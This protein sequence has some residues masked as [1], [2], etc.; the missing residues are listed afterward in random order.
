MVTGLVHHRTVDRRGYRA[1]AEKL[2]RRSGFLMAVH[3]GLCVTV[4]ALAS[5]A[6]WARVPLTPT[7]RQQGGIWHTLTG[8]AD[9]HLE[10]DYNSILPMYVVLLLWAVI[11]VA[12][13]H[14]GRR[15][16][17][18]AISL[19]VYVFGQTT[20]GLALTAGGFQIAA[21]QL[22]FTAGL[23]VGWEW[24]HGLARL[25]RH[26]RVGTLSAAVACSGVIFV[27]AHVAPG[28]M[29]ATFGS[30]LGKESGG[31][32]AFVYAASIL[33][34]GYAVVEWVRRVPSI[35]RA[36][37]PVEVLG[38]RGLPGYVTMVLGILVLDVARWVPR[39]DLVAWVLIAVC[40]VA[41]LVATRM[42]QR[43]RDSPEALCAGGAR[44][45]GVGHPRGLSSRLGVSGGDRCTWRRRRGAS[46]GRGSR[47]RCARASAR[48]AT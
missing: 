30:A 36:L 13:L 5:W 15:R 22:L 7:W 24:E 4:V 33:V 40:G 8:I 17:V 26:W 12:L 18:I 11:A 23:V 20:N 2:V 37:R 3:V 42:A 1:S 47:T 41:E 9:L 29:T 10:P 44:A 16:T 27:A 25:P 21:W 31:W 45:G 6:S 34:V 46:H 38:C 48:A 43:R 14:Q 32:L 19:A 39:N 28:A 35:A